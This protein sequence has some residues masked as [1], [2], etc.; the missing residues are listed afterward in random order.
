MYLDETSM[1]NHF[2]LRVPEHHQT[3]RTPFDWLCLMQQYDLPTR[4]LDWTESVLIALYFIVQGWETHRDH[5]N[6]GCPGILYILNAQ[7]LNYQTSFTQE[8][9]WASIRIPAS[10]DSAARSLLAVS[11][12]LIYWEAHMQ[13]LKSTPIWRPDLVDDLC[14]NIKEEREHLASPIAVFPNRL[15]GRMVLQSS[16]FT[17]HGG[18]LYPDGRNDSD[19]RIPYPLRLE[20]IN[21]SLQPD[22]QFLKRYMI[23]YNKKKVIER[24]LRRLGVH[25]GSLYPELDWQAEYI[26]GEWRR[27]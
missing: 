3:Y 15:N 14:A 22:E 6:R 8:R 18:K 11:R 5:Q 20:D 26:K 25:Q 27:P 17:I 2:Q 13:S 23:P 12:D 10:L 16:M 1:F 24:E 19:D 21:D 4:L 7:R 9:K